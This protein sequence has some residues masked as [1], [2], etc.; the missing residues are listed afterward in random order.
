M[1]KKIAVIA[2]YFLMPAGV[3]ILL[4]FAVENNKSMPCRSFRVHIDSS[5]GLSF[6]DSARVVSQ[7]YAVLDTLEGKKFSDIS[8]NRVEE[9]INT[10][11]Y[12]D[13]SRV[14]RTID[15]Y[16]NVHISQRVPVARVINQANETFYIDQ[17]GKL[18]KPSPRYTAR[19][20]VVSGFVN[21][22]YA[23]G[24]NIGEFDSRAELSSS[25]KELEQIDRLVRFIR[26][27]EFLHAWID[28]I[29]VTRQGNFELVPRNGS[30]VIEFGNL[31]EMEEKFDK[32]MKFYKNGLTHVGWGSYKRI[33]LQ[34]KNQVV[35]SK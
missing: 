11:Y 23:P 19:V 12:V 33:N 5:E 35:C 16:L 22:R 7:V 9:L 31:E 15:G 6:V 30:H 24:V 14:Y 27:D 34:F 20:M 1:I 21:T 17:Q 2:F 25:E 28:Q 26:K 18:M 29:Y 4:G 10:I 8:L 32:L 13:K 3:F